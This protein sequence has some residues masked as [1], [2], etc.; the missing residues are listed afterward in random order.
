MPQNEFSATKLNHLRRQLN[1]WRRS[2]RG[3][4]RLPEEVWESATS[5][6]R[7]HGVSSVA[8]TLR[9]DYYKLRRRS[10]HTAPSALS[11]AGFVELPPPALPL[12]SGSACSVELSDERGGKMTV[13]LP[14]QGPALLAMAEGFWKRPR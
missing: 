2:Q 4:T 3:R 6:A 13:H 9:L 8:R 12:L 11:A 7:T 1:A 10:K 14:D 5:L